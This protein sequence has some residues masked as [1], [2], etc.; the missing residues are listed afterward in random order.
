MTTST[1]YNRAFQTAVRGKADASHERDL[2]E[3]YDVTT[4]SYMLP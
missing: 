4:G 1:I 2:R 3:G